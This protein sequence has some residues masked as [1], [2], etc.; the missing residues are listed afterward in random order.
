[1]P[2]ESTS[3]LGQPSETNPTFGVAA[4]R[5][6]EVMR[7]GKSQAY[8]EDSVRFQSR[9]VLH[10]PVG[11]PSRARAQVF[12]SSPEE[13]L[14]PAAWEPLGCAPNPGMPGKP[15][16]VNPENMVRVWFWSCSC[17]CMNTL[18]LCSRYAEIRL[19]IAG[20]WKLM[21]CFHR[22]SLNLAGSP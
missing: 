16:N 15:G 14:S 10:A 12:F 2:S 5:L 21:N 13:S 7:S 18:R 17:I 8:G 6:G 3:A 22:S 9:R 4:E 11:K 19:C 20:P 1:M